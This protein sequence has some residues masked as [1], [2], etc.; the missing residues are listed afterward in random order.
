MSRGAG[1]RHPR[2]PPGARAQVRAF[3]GLGGHLCGGVVRM[4]MGRSRAIRA[5]CAFLEVRVMA[6]SLGTGA[7]A[8]TAGA[9]GRTRVEGQA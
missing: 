1:A 6:A 5:R 7:T 2:Q 4:L 9:S 8:L 3:R